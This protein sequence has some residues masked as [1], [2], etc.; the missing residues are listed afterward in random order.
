MVSRAN[1]E[2][3]SACS[4]VQ[5]EFTKHG[6]Y[7]SSRLPLAMEQA[8][9]PIHETLLANAMNLLIDFSESSGISV[10][11]LVAIGR[12]PLS[13]FTAGVAS[14]ISTTAGSTSRSESRRQIGE[15]FGRRTEN[16]LSDVE[17]GYIQGKSVLLT[18]SSTNQSKAL[19]LLQALYDATRDQDDP[20]LVHTLDTGLSETESHVAWRYLKDRQL[21]ETFGVMYTA[22]INAAG[23]DAIE[24]AKNRP[25][26]PSANFPAVSYNIVHNTMH[27]GTMHN[28]P[29]Q[30]GGVNSAQSQTVTYSP[31]DLGDLYRLVNELTS[32]LDELTLDEKQRKKAEAQITTIKAQLTDEPDPV[33]VK[34]AGKTLR[35]ITEG[36]IAGLLATAAQPTVWSWV[37]EVIQRLFA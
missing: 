15:R 27:V 3:L 17:I 23:I 7:H 18:Q 33:I 6:A 5:S 12:P 16:A 22:R 28:S 36:A 8:V 37:H 34:Q 29:V 4:Q 10:P 32:H 31:Q 30:Q 21:I 2:V 25:D 20:V 26:Q 11:Q 9:V 13:D 24:K 14:Y 19:C 1:T 35:N